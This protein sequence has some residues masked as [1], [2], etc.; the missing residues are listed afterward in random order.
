[1]DNRFYSFAKSLQDKK[2]ALHNQKRFDKEVTGKGA[3]QDLVLIS[4]STPTHQQQPKFKLAR[5]VSFAGLPPLGAGPRGK[6]ISARGD[7]PTSKKHKKVSVMPKPFTD[8]LEKP[9]DGLFKTQD[10]QSIKPWKVKDQIPLLMNQPPIRLKNQKLFPLTKAETE[11]EWRKLMAG[12]GA[13]SKD[14]TSKPMPT[15]ASAQPVVAP[16]TTAP[17]TETPKKAKV[18]PEPPSTPR[19]TS[20]SKD[21]SPAVT[22]SVAQR[23]ITEPRKAKETPKIKKK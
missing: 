15:E 20:V 5:P 3:T 9:P 19:K 23:R 2:K 4:G 13:K 16:S 12:K 17:V 6:T 14:I 22:R 11:A 7:P 21:S 18:L 10:V 1:M 8:R